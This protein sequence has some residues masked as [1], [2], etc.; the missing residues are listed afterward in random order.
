[1]TWRRIQRL[2]KDL[3]WLPESSVAALP[4]NRLASNLPFRRL[5]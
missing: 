2:M 4:S 1:M 5:L 3:R